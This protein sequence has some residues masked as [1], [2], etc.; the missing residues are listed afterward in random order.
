MRFQIGL[1]ASSLILSFAYSCK[2]TERSTETSS[3]AAA[4]AASV[5]RY[6]IGFEKFPSYIP[7]DVIVLTFDDGVD[8][9]F[10]PRVLDVLREK[11]VKA[12]FFI[13]SNGGS[14][15]SNPEM[16]KVLR[17]IV[18][19]G[20]ELANHT[21]GHRHLPELSAG[22]ID[23]ELSIV[24]R[25][26]EQIV[27]KRLTL[28]RAPFGE[29][30]QNEA[31]SPGSQPTYGKVMT[32]VAKH[33]V[34]IGWNFDSDDWRFSSGAEVASNVKGLLNQGHYGIL[35]FHSTKPQTAD[36][37][38]DIIEHMKNTGKRF[39]LVE[40]IMK[41]RWGKTSAEIMGSGNTRPPVVN[42]PVVTNP[43]TSN[44]KAPA[45]VQGTL[46]RVGQQ[47]VYQNQIFTVL[48][49]NN[50]LDPKIS[51]WYWKAGD[52]CGG[53]GGVTPPTPKP[54]LQNAC[55]APAWVAGQWYEV[56]AQV[57]YQ[58]QLFTAQNQRNPGYDP[59]ISTWFW[60]AGSLCN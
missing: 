49:E 25:G 43:G 1:V 26:V 52:L 28:V 58:G 19:E 36:S 35:L 5:A 24:A 51:H 53:A 27:G 21:A 17:R 18:A 10:T 12:S 2:T 59:K 30:Y 14:E 15:L 56:G 23:N 13:N 50:G 16:Q 44:C 4:D 33:G 48:N 37:I 54:P 6:N 42:P 8:T 47:V 34:H 39:L 60:S 7:K 45:W 55:N 41:A 20:H 46:Y 38:S 9:V 31:D 40:D 57:I 32:A 3:L 11:N 29:P 22:E